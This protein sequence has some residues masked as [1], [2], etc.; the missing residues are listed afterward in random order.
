MYERHL[1]QKNSYSWSMSEEKC[2]ECGAT[3]RIVRYNKW[4]VKEVYCNECH[5]CLNSEEVQEKTRIAQ[6]ASREGK[7]NEF[8]LGTY[9]I[10]KPEDTD[11]KESED[12]IQNG[13]ID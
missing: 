5:I 1:L 10:P 6:I 13:F 4:H 3:G 11:D 12:S 9:Q 7:L 8:Y 2:P